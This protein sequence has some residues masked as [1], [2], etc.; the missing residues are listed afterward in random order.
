MVPLKLSCQLLLA[1]PIKL[2]E[3]LKVAG[4]AVAVPVPTETPLT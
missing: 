3:R 2:L 1:L 4:N